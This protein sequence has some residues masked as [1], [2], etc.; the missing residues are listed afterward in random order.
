ML[1]KFLLLSVA[2]L[3][4]CVSVSR[5][6]LALDEAETQEIETVIR[7]YL[8]R[9][10]E[11][12]LEALD[13]LETR[14]AEEARVAQGTALESAGPQLTSSPDGTVLG[15]PDG[16]VTLV[17]FFDYNCGYCKRALA[18][19]DTLLANDPQLRIVLKEIPVL[20]PPSEAA[21]RVSLAVRA[22]APTQYAEFHNRLLASRGVA[23]EARAYA[24]VQELGI[25]EAGVRAAVDTPA[26][27]QALEE[28]GRLAGLL[29]IDGT[30]TYVLG[31]EIVP[32]AVGAEILAGKIANIRECGR[33]AC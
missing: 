27:A 22:T 30:P 31:N 7:D 19:K 29:Q 24:V 21:A 12:L 20:G 18:D 33:T 16:D 1:R 14:R 2:A 8:L 9:N 23:D 10:P 32:G 5:P 26:V 6:A 11:V 13:V 28:S 3:S 15:N 17:E 4:I 25:D